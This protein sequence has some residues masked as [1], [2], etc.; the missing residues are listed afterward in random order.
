MLSMLAV[1]SA[2][3]HFDTSWLKRGSISLKS[4]LITAPRP[5]FSTQRENTVSTVISPSTA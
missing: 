3:I 4:R 5:R 2:P 1:H